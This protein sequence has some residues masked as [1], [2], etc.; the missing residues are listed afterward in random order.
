M[1]GL[2]LAQKY[3]EAYGREMIERVD[4]SLFARV[5][6]G[7]CG[8]GS[9]CFDFDDEISRDHDFAPGF[10]VWLSDEDFSRYGHALRR[11][12]DSLPDRF[13]GFSKESIIAG[14]R[15]GVMTGGSFYRRFTGSP[16][17]P[18][19]NMDWLM[20][21]EAHLASATNG[22]LFHNQNTAFS[23]TRE[24]LLAF[25][26]EDVRRKKIAAR[27]AIMA[28]AGQYNLLRLI[29]REDK[30]AAS[31]AFARFAEASISMAH[32]LNRRY[33]PFYKWGFYNMRTLPKL[34]GVI[35]PLLA[36]LVRIPALIGEKPAPVVHEE[37][38]QLT[39]EICAA[40]AEELRAQALSY[41]PDSFLQGHISEIMEGIKDPQLRAMHPMTDCHN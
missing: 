27:A 38:F 4:P 29:R 31:L 34:G 11:A 39:E 35:A 24:K 10:C 22:R 5:S 17:G 37:A 28:Q 1:K 25:Y 36:S 26:P 12:Y 14:N 21:P 18:Q 7:L 20:T 40:T 3:Y 16:E 8:E 15:L 41:T 19:S 33:T 23:M 2:E 6:V 32:L 9:Q 13:C 30:V